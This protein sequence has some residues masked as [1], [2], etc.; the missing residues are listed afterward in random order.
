[1]VFL[2]LNYVG[3]SQ[4]GLPHF[5]NISIY[6]AWRLLTLS[7]GDL[8]LWTVPVEFKYYL[9]LPFA[10]LLLVVICRRRV[11]AAVPAI[12]AWICFNNFIV[13]PPDKPD[14]IGIALWPYISIFLMGSL[15]ALIHYKL[16][17]RGGVKSRRVR[18]LLELLAG[19]AF[20]A[21]ILLIP[22]FWE[23]ATGRS[24]D[25]MRDGK[26]YFLFGLLWSVF[27]LS[28]LNGRGFIRRILENHFLRFVG[29]VSF[30]AYLW[31]VCVLSFFADNVHT[32]APL[33]ITLVVLVTLAIAAVSHLL[34][35][36]PF[37]RID[38]RSIMYGEQTA[39][40]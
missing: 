38:F 17:E 24:A 33:V 39:S 11:A 4:F 12:A 14:R 18:N 29:I 26:P 21:V 32:Y 5:L 35:E 31:H 3:S 37:M 10:A 25:L 6:G 1:M 23:S 7:R 28:F 9:V 2:F 20:A 15:T 27:L 40:R 36:R 13:W 34:F 8:H 22:H 30:S 19:C 16:H